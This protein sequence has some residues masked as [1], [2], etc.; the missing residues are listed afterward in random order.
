LLIPPLGLVPL[1]SSSSTLGHLL[2]S[3][4]NP[5]LRPPK[6]NQFFLAPN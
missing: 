6:T 5:L 3:H 4:S 1:L 2:N